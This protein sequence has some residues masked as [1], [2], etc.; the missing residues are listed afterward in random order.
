VDKTVLLVDH[1]Q[2]QRLELEIP[3]QFLI[4]ALLLLETKRLVMQAAGLV[5]VF[6]Q[7][8]QMVQQLLQEH[9]LQMLVVAVLSAAVV[10]Q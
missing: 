2:V 10:V 9:K 6:H 3:Q 5:R 7:V 1:Q 8:V 4:L